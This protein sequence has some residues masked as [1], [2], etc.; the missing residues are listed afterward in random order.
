MKYKWLHPGFGLKRWLILFIIGLLSISIGISVITGFR[1]FGFIDEII[2]DLALTGVRTTLASIIT[3]LLFIAAGFLAVVLTI[4][5]I[6]KIVFKKNYQNVKELYQD[7]I[8]QQG[9]EIVAL[10]GGTGL[11]NLLR[12]LKI[13]TSNITAIVTVADDG[14]SSG[15]LRDELGM[16]PPGD[17]RNCLVALADAEPL[18]QSLFQYRFSAKGHLAGHNFGNLFIASLTEVL[19]DFEEAVRESSRVLAVKGKV[20]PATNEDVHLGAVYT[21]KTIKMGESVIPEEGKRIERVFLKPASCR[22]TSEV[23]EAIAGAE[24]IVIGPGSLYTSVIPNLMVKGIAEA[25][26]ESSA[27]KIYICNVMTQPGETTAYSVSDHI[28]AIIR[29]AGEG[30]FDYVIINKEEGS[31]DLARRYEEEGAFPVLVDQKKLKKYN[32]E[33]IAANLLSE[34]GYIRHDPE[35]LARVIFSIAKGR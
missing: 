28:E 19:G 1:V 31:E 5:G 15:K 17:I 22:A 8:L 27:A 2:S 24:I 34:E 33:I 30:I 6:F 7:R 16:L 14:G 25:I 23:L 4:R 32:L 21:D 26:R 29:N 20:L 18:M 35:E 9:P 11:S 3:G 12:G 10:G 13:Y